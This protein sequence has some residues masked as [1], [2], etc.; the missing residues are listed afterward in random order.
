MSVSRGVT[1]QIRIRLALT[2][3]TDSPLVPSIVRRP[4]VSS[5]EVFIFLGRLP[6]PFQLPLEVSLSAPRHA[7]HCFTEWSA[8]VIWL[9]NCTTFAEHYEHP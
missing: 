2:S 7:I 9:F 8:I 4:H 5:V 6:I 1:R 3:F